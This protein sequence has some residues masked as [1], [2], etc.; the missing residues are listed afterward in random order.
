[1]IM[2][3]VVQIISH[4]IAV[5][6]AAVEDIPVHRGCV[7]VWASEWASECDKAAVLRA[8]NREVVEECV[9]FC[10][11]KLIMAEIWYILLRNSCVRKKIWNDEIN[12][13]I[14]NHM[15]EGSCHWSSFSF[16]LP[17]KACLNFCYRVRRTLTRLRRRMSWNVLLN[18]T[19]NNLWIMLQLICQ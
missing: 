13:Y 11:L 12:I 19:V 5:T 3:T 16:D 18:P 15:I 17:R 8:M 10:V 6:M 1:M 14:K 7:C 2:M 4:I 9:W